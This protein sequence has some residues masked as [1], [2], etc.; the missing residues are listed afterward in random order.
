MLLKQLFEMSAQELR[1]SEYVI[2]WLFKDLNLDVVWSKHFVQ[3]VTGREQDVQKAE[4]IDAFK[5]LKDKYGSRLVQAQRNHEHFVAV[6]KD[7]AT[8]LNI[9]FAV[10]FDKNDPRKHKYMLYGITIMR[11]SP[12]KFVTNM[13]GGQDLPV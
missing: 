10:H 8:E 13:S 1:D 5:K 12:E 7:M 4:L 11:K 9:P 3:R 2:E 6:L